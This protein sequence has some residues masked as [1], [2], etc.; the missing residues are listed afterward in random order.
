MNTANILLY[1]TG[2]DTKDRDQVLLRKIIKENLSKKIIVGS[3]YD[4]EFNKELL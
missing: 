4:D 2:V 1:I 3:N